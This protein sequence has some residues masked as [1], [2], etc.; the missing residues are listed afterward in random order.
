MCVCVSERE[1]A[2]RRDKKIGSVCQR[3][4]ERKRKKER[5]CVYVSEREKERE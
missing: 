1:I 5:V 2:I 4:R 3:G